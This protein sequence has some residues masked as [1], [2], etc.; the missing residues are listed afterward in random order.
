MI[1]DV[2]TLNTKY[3]SYFDRFIDLYLIL[4]ARFFNVSKQSKYHILIRERHFSR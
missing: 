2:A 4:N 3:T 1:N